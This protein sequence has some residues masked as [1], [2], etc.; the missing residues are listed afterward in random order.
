MSWLNPP[1]VNHFLRYG[2]S[3]GHCQYNSHHMCNWTSG[4]GIASLRETNELHDV[5]LQISSV[6]D[7]LRL[8][9]ADEGEI[10][11]CRTT[12]WI[13]EQV[14]K[15]DETMIELDRLGQKAPKCRTRVKSSGR[16]GGGCK[17]GQKQRPYYQMYNRYGESC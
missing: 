15:A 4:K 2:S 8:A 17:I 14:K 16:G 12:E 5:L 1:Q 9:P 3:I 13:Q 11:R 6:L 7:G 10:Y